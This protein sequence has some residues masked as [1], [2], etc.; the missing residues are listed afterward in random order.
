MKI[1]SEDDTHH[2]LRLAV[3]SPRFVQ[4]AMTSGF[5]RSRPSRPDQ[6]AFDSLAFAASFCIERHQADR[7]VPVHRERL[8]CTRALAGGTLP[9][10]LVYEP[11]Q[12]AY[13]NN[14]DD[15]GTTRAAK[16]SKQGFPKSGLGLEADLRA[17]CVIYR[18]VGWVGRWSF[19]V[20]RLS[21]SFVIC[22]LSWPLP[23]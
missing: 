23:L 6:A 15:R 17:R 14:N 20:H 10:V 7:F 9:G 5:N 18:S 4:L 11:A 13:N 1:E 21:L 19:I 8:P 12:R 2:M 22:H 3:R 16:H